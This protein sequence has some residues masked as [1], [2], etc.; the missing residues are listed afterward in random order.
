MAVGLLIHNLLSL[1]L[2][3]LEPSRK[4]SQRLGRQ[5]QAR[6]DNSLAGSNDTIATAL[7]VFG[8][9]DLEEVLLDVA[10]HADRESGSV[11][12]GATDLLGVFTDDG[13]ARVDL[14]QTLVTQ[15]IGAGQVRCDIAVRSGE[16]GQNGLGDAG[17]GVV[18][19]LEGL[20]A[21]GVALEEGDGVG[22]DGVGG[23][24]LERE[25]RCK[26]RY[27][28]NIE[29]M[30]SVLRQGIENGPARRSRLVDPSRQ[31]GRGALRWKY[32]IRKR[33]E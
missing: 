29:I 10:S 19:E 3:L 32:R 23:E 2:S 5:H 20:G 13:E 25:R 28:G 30:G 9:I 26:N 7:L 15:S 11:V 33:G 6:R 16:V 12:D 8:A 17:V 31:S 4:I 21:V 14:G 27:T 18:A 24:M 1:L 22:D